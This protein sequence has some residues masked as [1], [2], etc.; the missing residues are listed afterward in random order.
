[1]PDFHMAYRL[2]TRKDA[3]KPVLVMLHG[4]LQPDVTGAQRAANKRG[5]RGFDPA[6]GY[7]HF[8]L[9]PDE[10]HGV[11]V[12][13]SARESL[14]HSRDDRAVRVDV[15]LRRF[16]IRRAR[17][18]LHRPRVIHSKSPLRDVK[19]V[20]APVPVLARTVFPEAPPAAAHIT[21]H[22]DG[23]EGLVRRWAE[24]AVVVEPFGD[25]LFRKQVRRGEFAQ[26]D[27]HLM[28]FADPAV[29]DD[30]ARLPEFRTAPLLGANLEHRAGLRHGVG[31]HATFADR[32]QHRLFH[33]NVLSGAHGR[34][35][36]RHMPVVGRDHEHRVDVGAFH[37]PLEFVVSRATFVG[38][39]ASGLGVAA[40]HL[41]LVFLAEL[42]IH[43]A[44]GEHLHRGVVER[45]TG[46]AA[47]LPAEADQRHVDSFTRGVL[48]KNTGRNNGRKT[49]RRPGKGN[50]LEE[51]AAAKRGGLR[52]A[53]SGLSH[54][55]Y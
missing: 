31:Q 37:D 40:L 13:R 20:R 48:A 1:M 41:R 10:A 15:L 49:N 50:R 55:L 5:G 21:L 6:P 39:R 12:A 27:L 18:E 32:Q 33:I 25:W 43:I 14:F 19:V 51:I 17:D 36:D 42:P 22:A 34:Q 54:R 24:P 2:L 38:S 29:A 28:H 47:H 53:F 26:I 11:R 52:R 35:G 3:V 16:P 4:P 44:N 8:P 46:V 9:L 45:P 23:V 30:L 7:E